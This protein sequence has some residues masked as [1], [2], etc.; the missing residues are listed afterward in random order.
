[1]KLLSRG[2]SYGTLLGS[3]IAVLTSILLVIVYTNKT[4][5]SIENN[6]PNTL[7]TELNSLS[8]ALEDV[9]GVV[10][11]ARIAAV[12]KDPTNIAELRSNIEIAHLRILD[13]RDTY[14]ANNLVNASAFH[15]IVAP[16]I[17]DLQIW[18]KEGI[19][20]FA[21]ESSITLNIIT[22]R[23]TEAFQKAMVLKHQSQDQAQKILDS[24][25]KRLETFQFSINTLFVLTLVLTFTLIFLLVHQ[26]VVKNKQILS[27]D[28]IQQQHDLLESLLKHLPLGIAVWGKNKNILS[29]NASF[30]EITGYDQTDMPNLKKWPLLA[31]PDPVYRQNVKKHWKM[32]GKSG[33]RCEYRVTCKNGTVKDIEFK[34][35]FLP[36]SRVI[37]TLTDVSERN[38]NEKALRESRRTE[39]RAKKMESLGLLAGGVA[40]DLN[41]ILSGIVSY[42]ELILFDLPEDH[43]LRKPIETI[44]ESGLRASAIVQDLLTVARGVAVEKEP[45]NINTVIQDYLNSPDFR[46]VQQFHPGVTLK[47]QLAG[48]LVNIMGSRVH[49]RKILMN[50]VSNAFEAIDHSGC[51]TIS[52]SNITINVPLRGASDIEEGEYVTLSV[53]DQGKGIS[54]EDLEKIFEP[55]YSK[56]VMGRSGTGLG[57]SV[58]WNVVQDH[59]GHIKVKSSRDGTQFTLFF[60]STH[61][62][63]PHHQSTVDLARFKG[64]G[65]SILVVDDVSTQRFI[66]SSIVEK[67]GYKVESVA[68]GEAAIEFL[69]RQPVDLI[70]LDMIMHPGITGRQTYEKIIE[71]YPGQKAIIISGFAENEDVKETLRLGAGRF[72]RK[73]LVIHELAMAIQTELASHRDSP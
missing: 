13:L 55:F 37:N 52:T 47:N 60:P 58:V 26:L 54:E 24:Q 2:L 15:A 61:Q 29:L 17:A 3:I 69:V 38:K 49:I 12:T 5:H 9:S 65:E 31:Y 67:L 8:L 18:I 11:A 64:K 35:A 36:D 70:L 7:F 22:D 68:S 23:I 28:K 4:L 57:L 34:A 62:T 45:M 53:S 6:L 10:S 16:A 14:V 73:P 20:G 51:V 39:A 66:T 41:N 42:P 1:M 19:S 32:A 27:K 25:R 56:K 63:E 33:S 43:K 50:L 21:P 72:L 71:M 48:D 30:T 59:N 46:L 40:H 44:R